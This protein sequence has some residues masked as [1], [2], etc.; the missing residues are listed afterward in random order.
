MRC[1]AACYSLFFPEQLGSPIRA[2]SPIQTRCYEEGLA[3]VIEIM[4]KTQEVVIFYNRPKPRGG[5]EGMAPSS[6][7]LFSLSFAPSS[8]ASFASTKTSSLSSA[9]AFAFGQAFSGWAARARRQAL[10]DGATKVTELPGLVRKLVASAKSSSITSSS[11]RRNAK[12]RENGPMWFGGGGVGSMTQQPGGSGGT[13]N[14]GSR[15]V[16]PRGGR[17]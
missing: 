3:Q 5:D 9:S 17:R 14:G 6:S 15:F 10:S 11:D 4:G 16:L 2:D 13:A 1:A 7:S 8:S 12:R